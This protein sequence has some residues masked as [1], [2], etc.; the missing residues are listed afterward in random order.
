MNND[1]TKALNEL[2]PQA[3]AELKNFFETS[4]EGSAK[5]VDVALKLLGRIN[6]NDSNRIKAIALQYQ[7]ARSMGLKGDP[8]RPL[9]AELSP[10]FAAA[11]PE[12]PEPAKT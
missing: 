10:G 8:L 11:P 7:I 4:N 3:M 5:K 1:A 2:A 12:L 6:G 9:L